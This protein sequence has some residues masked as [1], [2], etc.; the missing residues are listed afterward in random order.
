MSQDERYSGKL[1]FG[2]ID[3]ASKGWNHNKSKG[4]F[5]TI[6][7]KPVPA[8]HNN[9]TSKTFEK[10]GLSQ[11]IVSNL[12]NLNVTH[13]TYIQYDG[14]PQILAGDHTLIAAE[15][16]SGKTFAY[17]VPIIQQIIQR[18]KELSDGLVFNS[19]QVYYTWLEK[20][21]DH[22]SIVFFF[23]CLQ[24][25]V[26]TP[27]RELGKFIFV[28]IMVDFYKL[29]IFFLATQIGEVAEKLCAG[30]GITVNVLL[31]GRTK[32]KM[33]NPNFDDVDLLIGTM[34]ATSSK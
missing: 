1:K 11:S 34:G 29:I 4:D 20:Y 2:S 13:C 30:L 6:H 12:N 17:L 27:S 33:L 9:D 19:P 23:R 8:E 5:F 21:M 15:T 24:A 25:L 18:K 3:L 22:I 32:Q 7:P 14:I 28:L 16:G 31:G 10:L 26:L